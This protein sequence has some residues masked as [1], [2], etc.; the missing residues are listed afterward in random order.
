MHKHSQSDTI[1]VEHN[2]FLDFKDR[3]FLFLYK[4]FVKI[5]VFDSPF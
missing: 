5:L 3:Q 2:V 4:K 1:R